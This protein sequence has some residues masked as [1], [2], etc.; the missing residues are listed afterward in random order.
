MENMNII[1]TEETLTEALESIDYST[2]Y[3]EGSDQDQ[4]E[5]GRPYFTIDNDEVAD[6]AV[7]KIAEER[8][9]YERLKELAE[10]QIAKIQEKI[11]AEKTRAERRTAFLT[12][13][14][15][16]YFGTVEHKKTKT[17]ETY[18]LLSGTLVL[19]KG[20]VTQKY[21]KDELLDY[22]AAEGMDDYIKT[23]QEPKWGEFKK[24]LTFQDGNAILTDTG[25]MVECIH[26]E[27]KPDT[28]DSKL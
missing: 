28:F 3:V 2:G 8:S 23:T 26:V 4:A 21:D 12:S 14:L 25:E 16:Q 18:K 22:L 19:K 15:A 7:R 13:C 20:G 10:T 17:Q 5:G 9:D 24:L 1:A 6:W 27:E 11:E